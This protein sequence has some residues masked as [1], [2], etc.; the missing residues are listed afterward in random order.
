MKQITV[1]VQGM[2]CQHCVIAIEKS[3]GKLSGVAEV[4]VNLANGQVDVHMDERK[5]S[6]AE[7]RAAIENA[8]YQVMDACRP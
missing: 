7:L 2:T 4:A 6:E 1:K 5:V 8:G 3:V